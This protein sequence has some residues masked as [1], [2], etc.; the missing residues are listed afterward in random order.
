MFSRPLPMTY[1]HIFIQVKRNPISYLHA[2][3]AYTSIAGKP[4][5]KRR[6]GK[7]LYEITTFHP[8]LVMAGLL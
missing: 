8:Q 1:I 3:T 2:K 6:Y 4:T 5:I 7:I